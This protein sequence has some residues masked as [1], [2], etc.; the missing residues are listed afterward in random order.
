MFILTKIQG[1]FFAVKDFFAYPQ[2]KIRECTRYLH[3]QY[4]H[5]VICDRSY[6]HKILQYSDSKFIIG[7]DYLFSKTSE[8]NWNLKKI[9][10][11]DLTIFM[12]NL[13]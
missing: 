6:Y 9:A 10:I 3:R 8:D 5:P 13:F 7:I 12:T 2:K 1:L 4:G 11:S